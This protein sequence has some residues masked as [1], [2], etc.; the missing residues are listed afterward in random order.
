MPRIRLSGALNA[1]L[2]NKWSRLATNLDA[3]ARQPAASLRVAATAGHAAC[4]SNGLMIPKRKTP[5]YNL[6]QAER[7]VGAMRSARWWTWGDLTA[8]R[9]SNSPWARLISEK[10][11]RKHMRKDEAFE[12]RKRADGIVEMRIVRRA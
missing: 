11:L 12:T 2:P 10:G 7:L 3:T 1:K 9:I 5:M 8:L 6:T 4:T